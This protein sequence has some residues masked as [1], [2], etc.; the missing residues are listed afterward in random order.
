MVRSFGSNK[1]IPSNKNCGTG[2]ISWFSFGKQLY[3]EGISWFSNL[4]ILFHPFSSFFFEK[5]RKGQVS[6][7][8]ENL[9]PVVWP[10]G[11]EG[12]PLPSCPRFTKKANLFV[13]KNG[14]LLSWSSLPVH[15]WQKKRTFFCLHFLLC[16]AL[17]A[18]R[19][20]P[21]FKKI[22]FLSTMVAHSATIVRSGGSNHGQ[23]GYSCP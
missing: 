22:F 23:E 16:L 12:I 3:P 14:N 1:Y 11:Q 4:F 2:Q 17:R 10:Y 19:D 13:S 5:G 18:G 8:L 6:F 15:V 9:K 20:T 7:A 21:P